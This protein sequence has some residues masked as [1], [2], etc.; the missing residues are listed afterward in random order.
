M[1]FW[2][3]WRFSAWIEAKL[4]PRMD[5]KHESM[6]FF[7]LTLLFRTLLLRH[8]Q[9]SNFWMF[10]YEKMTYLLRLFGFLNFFLTCPF[11]S[12]D[13]ISY[14]FM[15]ACWIPLYSHFVAVLSVALL[16]CTFYPSVEAKCTLGVCVCSFSRLLLIQAFKRRFR[17]V[18]WWYTVSDKFAFTGIQGCLPKDHS[19]ML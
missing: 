16:S 14:R 12:N 9:K 2:T 8:A 18:F 10:L 5:S 19:Y 3:F 17:V 1:H 6:L 13:V 7:P 15:L 4:V 11:V